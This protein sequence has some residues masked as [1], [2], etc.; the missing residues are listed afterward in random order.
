MPRDI[1]TVSAKL[2]TV[3]MLT[4]QDKFYFPLARK[5]IISETFCPANL[6]AKYWMIKSSTAKANTHL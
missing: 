3:A 1:V 4:D 6:L 2:Q 5:Y